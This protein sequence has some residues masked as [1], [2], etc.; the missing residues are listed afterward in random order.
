MTLGM[1]AQSHI[2]KAIQSSSSLPPPA[3]VY[4]ETGFALK[5]ARKWLEQAKRAR[6]QSSNFTASVFGEQI[7]A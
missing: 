6:I 3:M 4:P 2:Y 1:K 7:R 5:Q